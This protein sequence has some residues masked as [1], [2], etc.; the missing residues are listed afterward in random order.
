[1]TSNPFL[2]PARTSQLYGDASRLANRSSALMRAKTAGRPVPETIIDLVRRHRTDRSGRLRRVLDVGCGRGGTSRA[3]AKGLRPIHLVGIDAAPA[4]LTAARQRVIR[5]DGVRSDFVQADFHQLPL[6][7]GFCDLAIAA[8]CLYHSARPAD[9]VAEIARALA[10]DGLAVLVTK[11]LD[12][13]REL[14][15]LV[16][17]A[18]L[19][20]C[21]N[22][23]ESL[24]TTAHS[25][26]LARLA[27]S[28]LNVLATHHEE[29]RF[30]FAGH[31]HAAEYLA[32]TPKYAFSPG[33]DGN[34][35]A[36][37]AALH[38]ARPDRPVT[39]SSTVTYVVARARG[40]RPE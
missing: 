32:T 23:H 9:V 19:D 10:P 26:N 2:D 8:F 30:T 20:P 18:G 24:Y 28:H 4:L 38:S 21:A 7:A 40:G 27:S 3:L 17:S 29:H 6:A 1:M 31:E 36:I 22:Q 5:V 33:L 11:S 12:S 13:Y 15:V 25:G 34:P 16:A 37:S 39:T 14:D 35:I